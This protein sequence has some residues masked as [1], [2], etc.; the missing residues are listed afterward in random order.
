LDENQKA[1]GSISLYY[2]GQPFYQKSIGF[3]D[4]ETSTRANEQTL[5]RVGSVSKIYTAVMIMQ[6]VEQG[7]LSLSTTLDK[8]FPEV[9]DASKISIEHLLK[10]QSGLYNITDS[11]DYVLY[12]TEA[13]DRAAQLARINAHQLQFE[14]GAEMAYSNSNYI[15]L[16][17]ILEDIHQKP[18][19]ELLNNRICAPCQITQTGIGRGIDVNQGDARS[20]TY[21]RDWDLLPE[22]HPSVAVGAGAV[23]SS[24]SAVNQFLSCLYRTEQL[25][26][27]STVEKMQDMDKGYGLGMFTIPFYD[28][29]AIGHTGGI[30]GFQSNAF[31][32]P[33]ADMSLVYLSNGVNM[34]LNDILI[35]VL[36]IYFER[37]YE[38][39]NFDQANTLDSDILASYV[40]NYSNP[41]F[42]LDINIFLEG[43]QLAAQATGQGAF[44]LENKS[45]HTYVFTPAQIEITFNPEKNEMYFKQAGLELIF[46]KK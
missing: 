11:T 23:Y 22:T 33:E 7:R 25:L 38:I 20:Y 37:P 2:E 8:F 32:F 1:M 35:G 44:N 3:S 14:P 5:Y 9:V 24:A 6:E 19:S 26:K 18:F 21:M 43:E 36:S 45:E 15:L 34:S 12:Y 41:N 17:Y 42:P 28:Q 39:P 40:G 16:T 31:Y 27:A 4:V 29:E 10:H 13:Q 30:D 46:T